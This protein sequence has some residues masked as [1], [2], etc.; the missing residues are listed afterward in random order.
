MDKNLSPIKGR[1]IKYIEYKEITKEGFY[2]S[3]GITA[4]NFKG[5]GRKSE[6]GGEKIVKILSLYPEI[7]AEWLLTGQGGMIKGEE[8]PTSD[9]PVPYR[10][11]E[12]YRLRTDKDVESQLVPLYELEASAGIVSVF[13]DSSVNVPL[14][15]IM[16]PDLPKCDGAV[17]VRGDSMYP[18]L[19]SGDI[20]LYKQITN[21]GSGILWGEMYLIAFSIDGD[22][23]I[24][25]KYV[26]KSDNEGYVRLVSHN[27]HHAPEEIRIDGIRGL[28]LIKASI[29]YNTM[30]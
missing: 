8:T 6:L 14:D 19:K 17:H 18:L 7:N 27:G 21:F 12:K 3:S 5:E 22:E 13:I 29:R 2:K 23:Y 30:G 25:V 26:Q 15:Y 24:T 10:I 1:I 11:A 16:I 4:S 20:I 28:A 9:A